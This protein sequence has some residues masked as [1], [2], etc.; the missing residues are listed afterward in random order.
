[1]FPYV[2]KYKKVPTNEHANLDGKQKEEFVK[3]LHAKVHRRKEKFHT[4]RKYKLQPR[5]V[6]TFQVLERINDN[7]Y[8]LDLSTAYGNVSEEFDSRT[9]PFEEGGND[10]NPTEK[11]K[12]NLRDIG[13]PMTRFKTKM[14]ISG[15]KENLEKSELEV[16]PKW[17]TLLQVAV[18]VTLSLDNFGSTV[19]AGLDAGKNFSRNMCF[20]SPQTKLAQ[21]VD[22]GCTKASTPHPVWPTPS[23]FDHCSPLVSPL[24]N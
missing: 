12:Y 19:V 17:V 23:E 1:M 4:K 3:E 13:D 20:I 18:R 21:A 7:A 11:D 16:A 9:N 22:I 2:I 6:G 8:K 14:M 24:E 10:R 15:I 5:G